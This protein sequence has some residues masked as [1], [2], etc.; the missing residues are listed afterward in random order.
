[1]RLFDFLQSQLVDVIDGVEAPGMQ[2]CRNPIKRDTIENGA[3]LTVREVAP[4]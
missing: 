4:V 2:A 1:M 3:R